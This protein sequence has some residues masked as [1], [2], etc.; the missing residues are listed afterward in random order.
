VAGDSREEIEGRFTRKNSDEVLPFLLRVG[1]E[2]ANSLDYETTLQSVARQAVP[3]LADLCV[4]D[5]IG[6]DGRLRPVAAAHVDAVKQTWLRELA[7]GDESPATVLRAF[8]TRQPLIVPEIS[9]TVMNAIARQEHAP[10][11]PRA[12]TAMR[13]LRIKSAMSM[14][15]VARD[16]VLG[17]LS[18]A[19]LEASAPFSPEDL[20]LVQQ[21]ARQCA[22]AVDN[23]R[24]YREAQEAVR[25]REEF[26]ATTSHE[27]RTPLSEIKGFVTTLLRTDVEWD[28]PTRQDFLREIDN[29]ADRLDAL[30]SD[31]LDMSR[32]VSGGSQNFERAP[33]APAVLVSCGVDRVRGRL[34]NAVVEIDR[35]LGTLPAV[36]VDPRRIEQV[37]ANLVENAIKYA[38]GSAIRIS[39]AVAD[40]G[41]MVDLWVED[42]GP[43]IPADDLAHI[44]DRFYRGWSAERSDA[45]G[46][47]L[48]L[49]IARTI[50]EG[51]GGQIR[52]ENRPGGG[53]RFVLSLPAAS[54]A[55]GR[56]RGIH[57]VE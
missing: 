51:H 42:E 22:L 39:G 49:A 16:R 1:E 34:F 56:R 57:E 18:L 27:L 36:W 15:L 45:P 52:A 8:R 17:V 13:V 23:A 41:R 32:L 50:V 33:T 29:D 19:R 55:L 2:L 38:P 10:V 12:T 11:S 14:P 7:L 28:Q 44:F 25:V 53:A 26:L 9:D 46:T 40:A 43:G 21:L 35:G 3:V 4:V 31:L 20:P 6:S 30:I 48:G 24:L 37:F 54:A 47:G 5:L